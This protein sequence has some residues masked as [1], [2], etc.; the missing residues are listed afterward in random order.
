MAI[1]KVI[2]DLIDLNAT[3]ATKS[4]KMPKGAAYS[5]TADPGMVRNSSET[6]SQGSANVMQH[7]NGT[8]WKNYEN[9]PNGITTDFLVVAGGGAGGKWGPGGGGGAGGLKTTTKYGGTESTLG[10]SL[11]TAY[12]VTVG[13]GGIP[14]SNGT[15]S[16]FSGSF[17][18]SPITST[19]GGRG[20]GDNS[21]NYPAAAGGSGGG[22]SGEGGGTGNGAGTLNQGKDGGTGYAVSGGR[23]G[24]GGGGAV[25]VGANATTN[26]G[27]GGSGLEAN[28]I[29]GTGNFYA[30][31]G[32]GAT[33]VASVGT[34][35]SGGGG[36]GVG[37]SV[38]TSINGTLN[39]GGGGGGGGSN[40]AGGGSG[41]VI[42]R[43]PTASVAS[44]QLDASSGLD[45]TAD[46]AYPIAN[47][48]YYKLEGGSGTTVTDSSGNGNNGVSTSVTYAAGRFG[49]AAVFNGSSSFVALPFFN[50]VSGSSANFTASLWFNVTDMS[51]SNNLIQLSGSSATNSSFNVQLLSDGTFRIDS[52]GVGYAFTGLATV[53]TNNW[54]NLVLVNAGGTC[55]PYLNGSAGNVL[56]HNIGFSGS[57]SNLGARYV[58]GSL[59]TLDITTGSIDQVRIFNSA[60]SAG[61]VTSLYNES[62]VIPSTDGTDSILQFIGGTGTVTFS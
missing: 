43:Y 29:G 21:N 28:I 56:T 24:G 49:Q 14:A 5:G 1:T 7:F 61:N 16:S 33:Q 9:L 11:S 39:T 46:T 22:G 47:T 19:G 32:G 51:S 50:F 3:D 53:S 17:T 2:N 37:D 57:Y 23:A 45:T 62:T 27:N 40:S 31:G 60:I 13:P 36:A 8:D 54:Y 52:Y 38:T 59:Y 4:L 20:A 25:A 35:G 42:L 30:G 55:T 41:V 6:G 10:L 15:D 48:A 34:G 44:Y 18:G 58:L 12:T 26:G